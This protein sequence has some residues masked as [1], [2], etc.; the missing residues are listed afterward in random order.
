MVGVGG[1]QTADKVSHGFL[2]SD[3]DL[4]TIDFPGATFTNAVG[5]VS[6]GFLLTGFRQSCTVQ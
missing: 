6:H 5:S 4:T 1:Y 2:L 3:G